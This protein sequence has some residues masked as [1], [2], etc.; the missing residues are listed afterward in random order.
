MP[1]KIR[2]YVV[3]NPDASYTIVLNSRLSKEM[4]EKSFKHELK[5]IQ[6]GDYERRCDVDIIEINAHKE[7]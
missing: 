5:H 2:A 3:S 7:E 6:N 4:L 1:T